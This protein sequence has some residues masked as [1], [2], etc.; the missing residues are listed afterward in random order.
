MRPISDE[1]ILFN[2]LNVLTKDKKKT[3]Y[4]GGHEKQM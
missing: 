3:N 1:L 4:I 2:E